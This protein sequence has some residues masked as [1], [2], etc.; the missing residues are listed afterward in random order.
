M[1]DKQINTTKEKKSV[2][3]YRSELKSS[4]T[5]FFAATVAVAEVEVVVE[6]DVE[7]DADVLETMK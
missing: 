1:L 2:N 3:R 7:V 6:V 4:I 5:S